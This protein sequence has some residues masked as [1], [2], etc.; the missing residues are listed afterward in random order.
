MGPWARRL[1]TWRDPVA[2]TGCLLRLSRLKALGPSVTL[3]TLARRFA[4]HGQWA[5]WH[6]TTS[7]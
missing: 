3:L 1:G 2:A 5:D 6:A 7:T 4:P